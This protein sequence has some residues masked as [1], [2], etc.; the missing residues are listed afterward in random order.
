MSG[1]SVRHNIQAR[2]WFG[3]RFHLLWRRGTARGSLS[4]SSM[5]ADLE[6]QARRQLGQ[7]LDAA[8]WDL[9]NRGLIIAARWAVDAAVG[10]DVEYD[11]PNVAPIG[12]KTMQAK[13][14][15]DNR[16]F[17]RCW[18]ALESTSTKNDA[19][20]SFLRL[21]AR[22]HAGEQVKEDELLSTSIVSDT[23]TSKPSTECGSCVNPY[24]E[25]ILTELQKTEQDP[26]IQYLN[27]VVYRAKCQH[28][29]AIVELIKSV[30]EYPYN[31]SAWLELKACFTK[32]VDTEEVLSTLY[33]AFKVKS[34]D[35][36]IMLMLFTCCAN[37]ELDP[38]S[39]AK[40]LKE[41]LLPFFSKMPALLTQLARIY[42]SE[43]HYQTATMLFEQVIEE[44]PFRL[45]D[46]D[47]YSNLLYVTE[48]RS[49]LAYLA[50]HVE[51][52]NKYRTESCC[53]VA[54]YYSLSDEHEKAVIHYKRALALNRNYLAAW[55]LMGHEFIELGNPH[56]AIESYRTAVELASYDFRPWF[57]LGQAYEVLGMHY[58]G[59]YYFQKALSLRPGD[60]R[61]WDA[62]ANCYELL[63]ESESAINAFKQAFDISNGDVYY[64]YRL[65]MLYDSVG[66]TETA[67]KY[68]TACAKSEE[69][70]IESQLPEDAPI[71][72][73]SRAQLWLAD[74]AV[75]QRDF[76]TAL[77]WARKITRGTR[78]MLEEAR[79]IERVARVGAEIAT[80]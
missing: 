31:W 70:T 15:F 71:E 58:F 24:L 43:G 53:I 47:A 78:E 35:H 28:N 4:S 48:Q 14:Y 16:E 3:A 49:K 60:V 20:G 74:Q 56:A 33:D 6:V 10:L 69:N 26:F 12:L 37:E 44:D 72:W 25:E 42:N 9:S 79:C 50:Q 52:T 57:G 77:Y 23:K 76:P 41:K 30:T 34:N 18:N 59:Q 51:A 62:L 75:K 80:D 32:L 2:V 38:I 36:K 7:S 64:G 65:G 68:L 46:L 66:K 5:E 13:S 63:K 54:N 22:Y 40:L 27:G 55:T 1:T 67:F 45:E 61:V 11:K 8:Y 21:F 17:L 29:I 39:S 19:V 73:P